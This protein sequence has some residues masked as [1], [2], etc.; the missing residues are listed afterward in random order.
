[1]PLYSYRCADG[2]LKEDWYSINSY[3][4]VVTCACGLYAHI[5]IQAPLSVKVAQDVAYDSPIDGRHITS[6]AQ[7]NEDLKRN[8]CV[9]YEPE[10]RQDYDRRLKDGEAK[11]DKAIDEHVEAT[12]AK[13][14]TAKRAKLYSELVD[15]GVTAEYGRS[16]GTP[17]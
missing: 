13:M 4:Q 5:A 1:M 3:P 9:P 7:R 14:S 15:Q 10:I 12:I 16:T 2:H 11:L 17:Q 8:N 6:H